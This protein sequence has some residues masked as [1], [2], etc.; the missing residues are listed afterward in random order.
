MMTFDGTLKQEELVSAQIVA[1]RV[2]LDRVEMLGGSFSLKV[3]PDDLPMGLKIDHVHISHRYVF[4]AEVNVLSV[5]VHYTCRGD[6]AEPAKQD[7]SAQGAFEL[8][9]TFILHYHLTTDPPPEEKQDDF[10]LGFAKVNGVFNSWPYLREFVQN[11]ATRTGIMGVTLPVF[12]V[13]QL[14][15][16]QPQLPPPQPTI[17]D[18]AE[19]S[20]V[21]APS[22]HKHK[23]RDRSVG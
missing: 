5:F 16:A 7:A 1:R 3:Q 6:S 13:P 8:E 2:E 11:S 14:T 12:R 23:Q 15:P 18:T 10:F 9:A 21:K 22:V 17:Q 19:R 4:S 20:E